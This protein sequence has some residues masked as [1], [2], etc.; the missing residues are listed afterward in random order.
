M[1]RDRR[2]SSLYDG[3]ATEESRRSTRRTLVALLASTVLLAGGVGV[4]V[5]MTNDSRNDDSDGEGV[6]ATDSVPGTDVPNGAARP[7]LVDRVTEEGLTVRLRVGDDL[8]GMGAQPVAEDA[9]GWC[10]VSGMA[11]GTIISDVAVALTQMP[12]SKLAS[13]DGAGQLMVGGGPEGAPIWGVVVQVPAQV[14]LVRATLPGAQPDEME[15][16]DGL[17]IVALTAPVRAGN[18]PG[19]GPG[20]FDPWGGVDLDQAAIELVSANGQHET[21]DA[22]TGFNG[23]A[24]WNDQRCWPQN[25]GQP[26]F[27]P[28]PPPELPPPGEQPPDPAA[29]EA[30]VS[31]SFVELFSAPVE[32]GREFFD[33]IDDASGIDINIASTLKNQP[34]LKDLLTESSPD[35]VNLV[36]ISP[37]EAFFLYDLDSPFVPITNRLGRARFVDGRWKITRGTFCQEVIAFGVWCGV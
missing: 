28:P 32:E 1:D 25:G 22:Q 35:V 27:E 15:P 34:E 36:F 18:A 21:L 17:A 10:E 30:A 9:P 13:P 16:I 29:A 37:V 31:Q 11:S 8:F 3:D 12:V 2:R 4:A 6:A 24:M 19:V 26:D 14:V 23:P 33:L 7:A 5:W 20:G